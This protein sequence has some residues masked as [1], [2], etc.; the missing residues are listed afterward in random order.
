MYNYFTV[1]L[2]L[3]FLIYRTR[4]FNLVQHFVHLNLAIALLLGL[5]TFVAGIE[6]ANEYRVR[7]PCHIT[8]CTILYFVTFRKLVLLWQ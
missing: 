4:I 1:L 7:L 6:Q 2:S 8:T 5:I 3:V